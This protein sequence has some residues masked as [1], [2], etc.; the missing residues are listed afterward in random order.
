MAPSAFPGFD[1]SRLVWS[2]DFAINNIELPMSLPAPVCTPHESCRRAAKLVRKHS[3]ARVDDEKHHLLLHWP[4][5]EHGLVVKGRDYLKLLI[6]GSY[7]LPSST[8]PPAKG[9][10]R[11]KDA[12]S[13]PG[14]GCSW[15]APFCHHPGHPAPTGAALGT[16]ASS[17]GHAYKHKCTARIASALP[18]CHKR[19]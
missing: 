17:E 7:V 18:F 11:G 10:P 12:P 15:T 1:P 19:S 4:L 9:K 13:P 16:S 5:R 14:K 2:A 3:K 6:K 8:Q